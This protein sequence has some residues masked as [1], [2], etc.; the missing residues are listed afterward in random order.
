[1]RYTTFSLY[2]K[3]DESIP[4]LKIYAFTGDYRETQAKA[5]GFIYLGSSSSTAY[6]AVIPYSASGQDSALNEPELKQ[7]FHIIPKR[8]DSDIY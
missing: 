5:T 8:W 1:M 7:C 4:L 2:K 6:A 3:R